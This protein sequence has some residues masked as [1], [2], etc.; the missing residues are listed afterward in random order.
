M[1]HALS[2]TLVVASVAASAVHAQRPAPAREPPEIVVT[3]R[4]EVKVMPDRAFVELAAETRAA[5][6]A[7]ASAEN[8]R[9]QRAVL[10]TLQRLGFAPG[11][12]TTSNYAVQPVW[13]YDRLGKSTKQAGYVVQNGVRVRVER[14]D[15]LGAVID[16]ALATGANRVRGILFVASTESEAQSRALAAAVSQAEHRARVAA[17]AGGGSL[18]P[19][20]QLT[21]ERYE[22]PPGIQSAVALQQGWVSFSDSAPETPITPAELTV[23]VTVLG[24]W[25]FAPAPR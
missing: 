25:E 14:L 6:A 2:A 12:V 7:A 21:T 13:R 23:V 11:A 15:R 19:L 24:R 10:D 5:T 17:Q 3:G 16:A 9:R 1:R 18:G 20:I 22:P 8:A 4:G